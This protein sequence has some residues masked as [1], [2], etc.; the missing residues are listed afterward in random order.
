[1]VLVCFALACEH[2]SLDDG[3]APVDPPVDYPVPVRFILE[4]Q[5]TVNSLHAQARYSHSIHY[6]GIQSRYSHDFE[7][8]LL[9][10]RS[11]PLPDS[12]A[13]V[14]AQLIDSGALLPSDYDVLLAGDSL[15][16][17][18]VSRRDTCMCT[19]SLAPDTYTIACDT[20]L[21]EPHTLMSLL[22]V[23]EL[24]LT[25]TLEDWTLDTLVLGN[26]TLLTASIGC[27]GP[28]SPLPRICYRYAERYG[29]VLFT[30]ETG[31]GTWFFTT[32]ELALLD[33]QP[34]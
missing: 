33:P 19:V 16:L 5:R 12:E 32:E 29:T 28:P 24:A 23:P 14:V 18:T 13:L 9:V 26:D 22:C 10:D 31:A 2:W 21:L 8:V 30:V 3:T 4:G 34:P 15:P 27:S 25:S 17:D 6:A 20:M 11:Y 7:G 1:M